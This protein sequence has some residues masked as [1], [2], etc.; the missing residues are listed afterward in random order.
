MKLLFVGD[1]CVNEDIKKDPISNELKELINSHQYR[2]CTLEAP[3]IE[4]EFKKFK[5]AGPHLYQKSG[6][7]H[8]LDYFTHYSI[9]NNHIM[10]YGLQGLEKTINILENNNCISMG[11]GLNYQDIYKYHIIRN[12]HSNI[13]L[14]S[15]AEAQF[16]CVK[17]EYN[18]LGYS[19]VLSNEVMHLIK[20]AKEECE[21]VFI[22]VHA[23]LE[24]ENIPLPE[25]R[26]IYK[27]LIEFGADLVIGSHPHVIQG[28]EIYKDKYIYYSLGNFFF[29]SYN[30]ENEWYRSLALSVELLNNKIVCKEYFLNV[31]NDIV[32]ISDYDN[33]NY[34]CEILFKE[35][36]LL[37]YKKIND[38]VTKHWNSY[39][40]LYYSNPQIKTKYSNLNKYIKHFINYFL[41]RY[42]HYNP[43]IMLLHN[44]KVDTHRFVVER[45]LSILEDTY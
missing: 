44:I 36:E 10:D 31:E 27:R 29:N 38:I 2:V 12:D 17:D 6:Y 43:Q 41:K 7:E 4:K 37:Y 23:G 18:L 14:I 28:K 3:I 32:N 42:L 9:S 25:W 39:Y 16:G 5:K 8:F 15:L 40:Y 33:F 1:I 11:A 34:L 21:F 26:Q 19:W 45:A 13:A 30:N 35:N 24:M 22:T 20:R